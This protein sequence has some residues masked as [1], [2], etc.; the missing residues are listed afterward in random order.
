[1]LYIMA[2]VPRKS[3]NAIQ[4]AASGARKKR[5]YK[6]KSYT[7]SIPSA[8]KNHTLVRLKYTENIR[9]DTV[10]GALGSYMYRI[11]DTYDPNFSGTGHQPYFRDQM[12]AIYKYSRVLSASISINVITNSVNTPSWICL[13]PCQSG[14]FDLDLDTACERKGSK[15][16]YMN[17]NQTKTLKSSSSTDYYFG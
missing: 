15:E 2:N 3:Q 13:S 9:V 4:S 12:Y 1:M 6:K 11:N 7:V 5:P 17:G 14:S 16:T 8:P 10:L